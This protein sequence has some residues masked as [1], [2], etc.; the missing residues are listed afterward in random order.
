MNE[1]NSELV[2][3]SGVAM[4]DSMSISVAINNNYG[5]DFNIH[6]CVPKTL[7]GLMM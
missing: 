5:S 7:S 6:V 2:C 4:E 1:T 3:L